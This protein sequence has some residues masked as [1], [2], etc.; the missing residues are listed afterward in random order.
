MNAEF[1]RLFLIGL[2]KTSHSQYAKILHTLLNM[3]A[4]MNGLMDVGYKGC[5]TFEVVCGLRASKNRHT[6]RQSFEKDTR[7]LE[8]TLDMQ[9]DFERLLYTIG[10][11]TLQ[12]Y[13]VFEE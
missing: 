3:D 13:G 6:P 2:L 10:K 11:H 1:S 5:F 7:L 8:P 9:I 12:S 4:L